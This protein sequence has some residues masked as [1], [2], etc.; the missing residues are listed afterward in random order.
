MK[1]RVMVAGHICLDITPKFIEGGKTNINEI[2]SPGRLTNVGQ[3]V[4]S[5]GGAV[6]NTGLAM[7]KL[8]VDVLLNGKVGADGFGDIIKNLV[9]KDKAAAF[10]TVS[11]QNS[12]YTVVLAPPGIDRIFLHDPAT[13]DTFGVDD[14]DYKLAGQCVLFHFGYPPLMKRMYENGGLELIEMYKRVKELG[15]TTSLDMTVPDP[16]SPSGKIDWAAV[17]EKV[18]PYLDIFV[19]S[20]EEITYML[21]RELFEERKAQA[22][23]GDAVAVYQPK[24]C[25]AISDRLISMGVKIVVIKCGI[26]GL[27]LRTGSADELADIGGARPVNPDEWSNRE[28][29]AASFK[30]EKFV[31]ALG[32]GDSTIAGFLTGLINGFSPVDCL[33]IANIVGLQNVQALDA[34]SGVRDWQAT[35]EMLREKDRPLNP[36][37]LDDAVGWRFLEE[38][39]IYVGPNDKK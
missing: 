26:C 18:G 17:L 12:S 25:T 35:L 15:V 34:V 28:L 7:A 19:P 22:G 39:K 16:A 30:T 6:S 20:I 9:G 32:A 4:L 37:G 5:T 33:K 14:I 31:S 1:K 38:Q 24:D 13:N 21:D 36:A 29:W 2:L 23:G 8:G 3:A 11:D 27:Y 10:K